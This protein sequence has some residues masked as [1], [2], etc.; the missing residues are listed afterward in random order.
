MYGGSFKIG[1]CRIIIDGA[2]GIAEWY[3]TMNIEFGVT[4][5]EL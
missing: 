2:P 1:G 5:P 4:R 3:R